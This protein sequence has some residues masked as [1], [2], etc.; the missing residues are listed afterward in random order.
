MH[1]VTLA[2][3][4]HLLTARVINGIEKQQ[5]FFNKSYEVQIMSLVIY[6]LSGGHTHICD[7]I[8]ENVRSSH[9]QFCTFTGS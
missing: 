9:I 7:R 3:P 8:W 6:G 5:E 2:T 4:M 1:F